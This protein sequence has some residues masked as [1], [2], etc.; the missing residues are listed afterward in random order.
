MKKILS[1]F[2]FSEAEHAAVRSLAQKC[3][4][5]ELTAGILFSR[6]ADTA[7]KVRRFLS[8]SRK[9]FVDPFLMRGMRELV[10]AVGEI[11]E[12]GRGGG[13]WRGR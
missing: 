5:H 10:A 4:L 3:G 7:D 12:K 8:P 2:N 6:G 11:K 1:E 13:G 9:N